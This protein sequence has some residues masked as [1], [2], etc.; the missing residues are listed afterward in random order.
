LKAKVQI[1]Q[2]EVQIQQQLATQRI[3]GAVKR[4]INKLVKKILDQNFES[5]K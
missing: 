2:I 3:G 1:S 5:G 4:M